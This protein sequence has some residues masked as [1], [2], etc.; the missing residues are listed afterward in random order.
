MTDTQVPAGWYADPSGDATKLRY[1]DGTQWT[2]QYQS[3][4][5]QP[6]PSQ[7]PYTA[8]T[9]QNYSQPT[10]AQPVYGTGPAFKELSGG[11]KFGMFA[12]GLFL[13]WVG[14][15]IAWAINKDTTAS[16]DAIKFS[17]IGFVVSLVLSCVCGIIY[18]AVIMATLY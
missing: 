9:Q 3:A 18:Y 6:E 7:V 8:H 17:V 16:K 10:Y 5:G 2:E 13:N 12:L 15:I 1:W 14:I 11:A 4:P